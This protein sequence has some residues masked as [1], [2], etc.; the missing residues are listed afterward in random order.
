MDKER[1]SETKNDHGALESSKLCRFF[2]DQ[3]LKIF[4]LHIWTSIYLAADQ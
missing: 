2:L 3:E 4:I 1:G